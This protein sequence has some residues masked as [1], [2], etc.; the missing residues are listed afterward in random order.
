MLEFEHSSGLLGSMMFKVYVNYS[1][2]V[3]V[4]HILK[5]NSIIWR[6]LLLFSVNVLVGSYIISQLYLYP[7]GYG[8]FVLVGLMF[9]TIICYVRGFVASN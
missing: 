8:V 2:L 1:F 4:I 6:T 7:N 9:A 3:S 5:F